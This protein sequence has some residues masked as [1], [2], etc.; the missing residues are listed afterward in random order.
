MNLCSGFDL[1]H[2]NP[3]FTQDTPDKDDVPSHKIWLQK[4]RQFSRYY[5]NSH[6]RL[7]YPSKSQC[8]LDL[9][10]CKPI[11]SHDTLAHDAVPPYQVW[12]QKVQQLRFLLVS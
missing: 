4:D 2:N 9:E 3:L 11:L 5:R 1:E 6:V 10:H 8:D 12:L 7:Y